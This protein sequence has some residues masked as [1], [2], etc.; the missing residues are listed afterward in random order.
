ML[1][2]LAGTRAAN[3]QTD[4]YNTD[5]GRPVQVEDAFPVE[6]YAFELQLA[7]IRLQRASGGRY[8]WGIEPELAYG[9]FPRTQVEVGLPFAIAEEGSEAKGGLAGL[10]VS[11]LHNLNVE[12]EGLPALAL[13]FDLL[14]PVGSRAPERTFGTLRGLITRTY[15]FARFHL[16]ADY[17]LGASP[18][19]GQGDWGETEAARWLA[20]VAVDK[21]L[22]LRSMLVTGDVYARRPLDEESELEWN[23]SGGVRYQLNPRFALDAGVGRRLTGSEQGWFLTFGTAYAFAIR[24]LIPIA[25]R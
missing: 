2:S 22:P 5:R 24:A 10:D 21:T 7:P 11:L 18:R 9:I 1:L 14:L 17:T 15:G 4:Y 13:G 25:R 8:S 16:N 20:G 3:A 19:P 6:R 23:V 12:T